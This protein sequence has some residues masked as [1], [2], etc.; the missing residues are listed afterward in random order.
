[1]SRIEDAAAPSGGRLR[2]GRADMKKS[3]LYEIVRWVCVALVLA[4]IVVHSLKNRVSGADPSAVVAAV[5]ATVNTEE[6]QQADA[7]MIKRLYGINPGD[8]ESCT[9]YYP[10]TNMGADEL[11][12]VKL[13]DISQQEALSAAA[14]ARLQTQKTAFDG[15]GAEQFALLNDH[16]VIEPRGNYFLFVVSADSEAAAAAF[17]AAL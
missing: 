15:Y 3:Q 4:L 13:K 12:I 16:A 8:Y 2:I 5:T 6:M 14:E 9:L 10:T 7:Q 17:R 11:L 1:M